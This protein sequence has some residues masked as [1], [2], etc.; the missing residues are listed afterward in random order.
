MQD[1]KPSLKNQQYFYKPRKKLS[2]RKIKKAIPFSIA[3]NE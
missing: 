3:K 2:E 1:T